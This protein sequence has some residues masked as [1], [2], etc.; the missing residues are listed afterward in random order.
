[1]TV[2]WWDNFFHGVALDFWTAVIPDDLTVAEARFI[3]QHL[4][5]PVGAAILDVP[6]GNGRLSVKLAA[7]GFEMTGVD[8]AEEYI[9][10]SQ[11]VAPQVNWR[12]ADMRAVPWTNEFDGA[13]CFGN[14]FGYF[15]DEEN[16]AALGSI[17]RS[18]KAGG[19]FILD[20][21]AIAECLLPNLQPSRSMEIAG[22]KVDVNTRY[23]AQQRRMFNDFTFTRDGVTDT[24]PS[25]QRI[26]SHDELRALI[27]EAGLKTVEEY[28]SLNGDKFVSGSPRLFVICEKFRS[29]TVREGSE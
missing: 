3:H 27:D 28:S 15:D 4:Q 11:E 24:R 7:Q 2:N 26:Y 18:L 16:R 9:N 25:S 22:I 13:F 19:R 29:P 10:R 12:L 14:S 20:A 21:P 1:M 5:L 6:C 23:D 17:S 8:M